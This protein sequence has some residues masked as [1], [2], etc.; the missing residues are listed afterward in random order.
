MPYRLLLALLLL[1]FGRFESSADRVIRLATR[2][3]PAPVSS[4]AATIEFGSDLLLSDEI[5]ANEAL[6]K[7][8]QLL[9]AK[10]ASQ[11]SLSAAEFTEWAAAKIQL[12]DREEG[13]RALRLGIKQHPKH[14]KLRSTYRAV[15]VQLQ[16][17]YSASD[18]TNKHLSLL[19]DMLAFEPDEEQVMLAI[20]SAGTNAKM[21]DSVQ[22]LLQ[23]GLREGSLPNAVMERLATVALVRGDQ[24]AARRYYATL[25]K[26][27]AKRPVIL[28]NQAW[29]LA[30]TEPTNIKQALVLIEQAIS[31]D[32]SRVDLRGT[33]G[34]ILVKLER[35]D[36]AIRDLQSALNGNPS[37]ARLYHHALAAAYE[38]SGHQKLATLHRNRANAVA[39]ELKS[40][41]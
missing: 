5:Q 14:T 33:R 25:L 11:K 15:C 38:K 28:N 19:R 12:G 18:L 27:D 37:H 24:S 40:R 39:E 41:R 29:L 1:A 31:I 35:W 34:L 3:E 6:K 22:Q 9:A 20:A 26:E 4:D 23:P 21:V 10:F 2:P 36:E 17:A 13:V 30:H 7:S 32:K 8:A 16:N